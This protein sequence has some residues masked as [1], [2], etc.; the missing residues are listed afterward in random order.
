M[1]NDFVSEYRR[2]RL[3]GE[4]ALAQM[5]DAALN[6]VPS[7]EGNSAAMIVRHMSGNLK[8]RFT[9]FLTTDGEKPWRDREQEFAERTST[10][11]D[12]EAMWAEGF[13][14]LATTLGSMSDAGLTRGVTV[15]G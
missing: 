4:K 9:D 8:A 5:P 14:V 15:G 6:H 2:Y 12:V 10:R 3:L 1:L 11:A 13:A 7:P